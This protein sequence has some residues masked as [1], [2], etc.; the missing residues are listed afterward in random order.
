MKNSRKLGFTA[1][2]STEDSFLD[3]FQELRNDRL[4]P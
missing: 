4:I 3:L 2:Q 1:Y